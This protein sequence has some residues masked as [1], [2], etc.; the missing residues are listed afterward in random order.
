VVWLGEGHDTHLVYPFLSRLIDADAEVKKL[1]PLNDP[2][3]RALWNL[4]ITPWS[5]RVWIVQEIAMAPKDT[6]IMVMRGSFSFRMERITLA[7]SII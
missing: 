7:M 5:S 6:D 4:L 2:G 3:N 1:P